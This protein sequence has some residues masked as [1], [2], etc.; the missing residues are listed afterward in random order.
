MF[1]VSDFSHIL[2]A[3][4]YSVQTLYSTAAGESPSSRLP[5]LVGPPRLYTETAYIP[6]FTF[7]LVLL[8]LLFKL[9]F[10]ST[11][12]YVRVSGNLQ[13]TSS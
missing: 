5:L 2:R 6:A 13:E 9:C 8:A 7:C 1:F 10:D 3:A 4:I 12:Y 11:E